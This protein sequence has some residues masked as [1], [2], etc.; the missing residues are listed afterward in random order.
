MVNGI[1]ARQRTDSSRLRTPHAA[2]VDWLLLL[3]LLLLV[4]L[5]VARRWTGR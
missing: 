5:L 2:P 3:L 4:V 1:A